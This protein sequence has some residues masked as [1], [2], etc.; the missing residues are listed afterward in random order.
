ME[1]QYQ[2][3]SYPQQ[4]ANPGPQPSLLGFGICSLIFSVIVGIIL[5]AIGR[6]KGNAYIARG[7][8]LTGASKAGFIM[9]KIGF[10]LSI[11]GTVFFVIYVILLASG[12]FSIKSYVDYLY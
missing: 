7:G 6:S 12:A 1:Q 11:I 2:G 5:G 10:I 8:Q 3:T 4:A 9:C